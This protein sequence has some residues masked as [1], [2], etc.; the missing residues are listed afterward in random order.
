MTQFLLAPVLHYSFSKESSSQLPSTTCLLNF[1]PNVQF[2]LIFR[3][4]KKKNENNL[5]SL[6]TREN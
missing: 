3:I 6:H 5:S 2:S 4:Q 1:S